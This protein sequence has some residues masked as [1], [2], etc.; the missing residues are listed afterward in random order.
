M[1]NAVS[2]TE[3]GCGFAWASQ[4]E[5]PLNITNIRKRLYSA[6]Q[7]SHTERLTQTRSAVRPIKPLR[8]ANAR[9]R[10]HFD[11]LCRFSRCARIVLGTQSRVNYGYAGLAFG[12]K[13][14]CRTVCEPCDSFFSFPISSNQNNNLRERGYLKFAA[15]MGSICF[16]GPRAVLVRNDL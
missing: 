15:S 4:L 7:S 3:E 9:Q 13:T 1:A 12:H 10:V 11:F 2:S 14:L 16:D 5:L 8:N 6:V